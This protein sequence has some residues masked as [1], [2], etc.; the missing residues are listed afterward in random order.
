MRNAMPPCARSPPSSP[1]FRPVSGSARYSPYFQ[2]RRFSPSQLGVFLS[3]DGTPSSSALRW[4]G[5]PC[6]SSSL[7]DYPSVKLTSSVATWQGEEKCEDI[8]VIVA[9]LS[10]FTISIL[11]RST[12]YVLLTSP[13]P[14]PV[15]RAR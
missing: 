12:S 2:L 9:S 11:K 8:E 13:L 5:L 1:P 4:P 10:I 7:A 3:S 6:V 15:Y 14:H